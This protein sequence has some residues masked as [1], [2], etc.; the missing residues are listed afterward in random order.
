[1]IRLAASLLMKAGT[2]F[3]GRKMYK[4]LQKCSRDC[5]KSQENV[6]FDIINYA[7]Q[8]LYGK[9]HQF[10]KIKS[11]RDFQQNVPINSYEDLRPYIERQ[12]RGEENVLFPG[13]PFFYA[14]SSGTTGQPKLIPVTEKYNRECYNGLT[15][16]WFYSMFRECPGFL[17][18]H[19]LTFVGKAVEGYT[20]D[21]TPFGS[22]SGHMNSYLP[23]FIKKFR[24]VPFQ[25]HNIDDYQAKYYALLRVALEKPIRWIVAANPSTLVEMVNF[26]NQ[27]LDKICR[28]MEKG[29]LSRDFAIEDDIRA[30]IEKRLKPN[31]RQ[32]AFLRCLKEKQGRILPRHFWPDLRMI[33]TWKCGNSGLYLKKTEGFFPEKTVIR[34]FGYIAT[35]A[36][37]GIILYNKQ[38]P[39]IL[40]CHMLFFEFIKKE[41][42]DRESPRIY[43]AHELEVGQDYYILITSPAGLY[44]YNINDVLRVEGLFNQFPMMRFIQKGSGISSL[45]GEK[46]SEEQLIQ[47]VEE[48][49]AQQNIKFN[50]FL[51]FGDIESSSYRLFAEINNQID[52]KGLQQLAIIIDDRLCDLNPEYNAKRKTKR[53]K[54]LSLLLLQQDAFEKYKAMKMKEGKREGQFKIGHLTRDRQQ[55][56]DFYSLRK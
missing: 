32:A 25:I 16:L 13:K 35:E 5:L 11:V 18:G 49:S 2:Y 33:N 20:E 42:M 37:A 38:L 53:I 6:L 55:Y 47:A 26:A 17:N 24:S 39:S 41:E 27:Y 30:A 7:S 23:D 4:N 14:T 34:E 36:R 43:L 45:T 48:V 29:Q 19:D 40:A 28:D 46:L 1:M 9:E 12:C 8:S 44:R 10:N 22:L 50:F 3:P 15:R 21:G 31:P 56:R 54:S 52:E 51:A